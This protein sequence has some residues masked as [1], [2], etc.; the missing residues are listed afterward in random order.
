MIAHKVIDSSNKRPL[1]GEIIV[2]LFEFC[3]LNCVFCNQDHDSVEGMNNILDKIDPI[4]RSIDNLILKGK[5][6]FA[7]HIMGG[8]LF[9][10]RIRDEIFS[11]YE[12]LVK[13]IRDYSITKN[14]EIEIMF[15]TNLIWKN[16]E[17][18]MSF[19]KDNELKILTSYDPSGRFNTNTIEIFK[20]NVITFKEYIKSVNVIMT[21][22]N[23][24]KFLKNDVPFFDYLYENFIIFFDN[25]GPGKNN[26][27]L[28]PKDVEIRDF[29]KFMYDNWQNC[30]P[31]KDFKN[32]N[33]KKMACMDTLTIMPSGKWGACGIF[34][35]IDHKIIKKEDMEQQWFDD[36]NCLECPHMKRC[37]M[38]CFMLNHVKKIRTQN[39]C[40][41]KEVY[42][43]VDSK[44]EK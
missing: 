10:D 2:I 11:D 19:L 39:D 33:Y 44:G 21:K 26:N 34:E 15:V 23:M 37:T 18:V 30:I 36:Y 1:T 13:E 4:K 29:M 17:R 28:S 9:S 7:I 14:I 43:Y 12:K 22:Q 6:K 31:F 5:R 38:G 42:D 8:E 40:F 3:D 27:F 16:S 25:Y 35:N 32:N 41:L 24:E 20:Y